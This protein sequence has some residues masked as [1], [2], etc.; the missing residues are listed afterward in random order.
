MDNDEDIDLD[1]LELYWLT[2]GH[3]ETDKWVFDLADLVTYGWYYENKVCK[4][5]QVRLYPIGETS[6]IPVD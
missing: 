5:V 4:L 1:D 6:F 2:Y 3:T